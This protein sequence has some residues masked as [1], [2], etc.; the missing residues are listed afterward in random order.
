MGS[1]IQCTGLRISRP[2]H[3]A[4]MVSYVAD[5]MGVT[6]TTSDYKERVDR[7]DYG[8]SNCISISGRRRD[9]ELCF[10]RPR[11]WS[12]TREQMTDKLYE[13]THFPGP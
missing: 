3:L 5:E 2:P 12:L 7:T 1:D 6:D 13:T 4:A 8:A 10:K 9:T 11:M